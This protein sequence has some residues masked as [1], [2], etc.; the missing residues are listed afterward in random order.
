MRILKWLGIALATLATLAILALIVAGSFLDANRFKDHIVRLVATQT[1][2]RLDLDG[3]I[4]LDFLPW[5]ALRTERAQLSDPQHPDSPPILA[6]E[7]ARIA[8]R[9]WPLLRGRI[10][11]DRIDIDGAL[12]NL[13]RDASGRGNW[14]ALEAHPKPEAP[15]QTTPTQATPFSL[16]GIAIRNGRVTWWDERSESGAELSGLDLDMGA[17]EEARPFDIDLKAVVEAPRPQSVD[18]TRVALHGNVEKTGRT[19]KVSQL[20][21]AIAFEADRFADGMLPLQLD[22]TEMTVVTEPLA[23]AVPE[24]TVRLADASAW[25]KLSGGMQD[26]SLA[27]NANLQLAPLSLRDV[28]GRAGVELPAMR[29]DTALAH[30][31]MRAQLRQDGKGLDVAPLNVELDATRF[32]G[33]LRRAAAEG[34]PLELD[35]RGDKIDLTGYMAPGDTDS[36]PFEFPTAAL[37]KLGITG[38]IRLDHAQLFDVTMQDVVIDIESRAADHTDGASD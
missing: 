26:G 27:V 31:A 20:A 11:L 37:A 19:I 5:L 4:K 10:E 15:T 12:L 16:G 21:A 14:E 2:Q 30:F 6:W 36:E 29:S 3:D 35:L 1:G 17:Y 33:T 32:A 34:A 9:L 7:R 13:R 18:R 24:W 8:A 23:L 22:V 25:G 28:L 38:R